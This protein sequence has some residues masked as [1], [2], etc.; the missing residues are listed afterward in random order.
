MET[1]AHLHSFHHL[2]N[3]P[4]SLLHMLNEAQRPP[5][6]VEAY[7]LTK[8]AGPQFR[9]VQHVTVTFILSWKIW[10][11]ASS[12]NTPAH[13]ALGRVAVNTL[14][15]LKGRGNS[16]PSPSGLQGVCT[17]SISQVYFQIKSK[18]LELQKKS[19]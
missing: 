7:F 16:S 13:P 19:S 18:K 17:T 5:W 8:H 12:P 3:L 6:Q 2:F 9:G 1:H 10:S 4:P 11:S 15:N 14:Q